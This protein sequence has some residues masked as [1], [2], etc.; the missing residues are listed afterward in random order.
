MSLLSDIEA[1]DITA[2]KMANKKVMLWIR[3]LLKG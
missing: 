1:D 2:V 3:V